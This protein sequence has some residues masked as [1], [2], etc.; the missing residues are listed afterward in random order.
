MARHVRTNLFLVAGILAST[1]FNCHAQWLDKHG[2][3]LGFSY[4]AGYQASPN[5]NN[6][7]SS[8]KQ[9]LTLNALVDLGK[10]IGPA[11]S[12]FFF[13]YQNH[14]GEHGSQNVADAQQFDGLDD[15]EY[16]RIHMLW[17]QQIIADGRV[18]IKL[19]KVEPK[20]E[21]F[22]PTNA[23]HHF[24]VST[25]RSPTIAAQGPPSMSLNAFFNITKNYSLALGVYDAS[26]NRG[27][28]ENTLKLHNPF[29]AKDLA[30]FLENRINWQHGFRD[31]PGG[32]KLGLWQLDGR[33]YNYDGSAESSKQGYYL[34]L[35]Q[36]FN[37]MGAGVYFQF[38][39]AD[40]DLNPIRQHI[41][42]GLQWPGLLKSRSED[43]FGL[44]FS[45]I[46]FS[47]A[48]SAPYSDNSESVIEIFYKAPVKSWL[49]IQAD[50]QAINNPGGQGA[51]D[52]VV[53][54]F[55]ISF[56]F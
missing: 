8:A 12:S 30:I 44:G 1:A 56:S 42:L 41:G 11:N 7:G 13:Q 6:A 25:E 38:G 16:D 15:P 22:A 50:I 28:D 35:D 9:R 23:A 40:E 47:Q 55:R 20:S 26:W 24:S 39:S 43:I 10:T 14:H 32:A 31:L 52:V 29:K 3:D 49:E 36:T 46:E 5:G 54:T 33:A 51:R 18:R 17:Y 27:R 37:D 4:Q 21:F 19:G 53:S 48:N 34:V 45:T 2:V